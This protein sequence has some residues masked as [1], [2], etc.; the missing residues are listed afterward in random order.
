MPSL[1]GSRFTNASEVH[2]TNDLAVVDLARLRLLD[3]RFD[4][5]LRL[6]SVG[7]LNGSD[8]NGTVVLDVNLCT[9]LSN[10]V[11][12]YRAALA[13]NLRGSCPD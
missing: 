3:D 10:D 2:Q 12:D 5:L 9:G 8:G 11:L 1:P 7:S 4:H 6:V 13:D